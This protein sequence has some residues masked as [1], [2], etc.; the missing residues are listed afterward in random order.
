MITCYKYLR[1][2]CASF[3]DKFWNGSRLVS[4]SFILPTSWFPIL[5]QAFRNA[6]VVACSTARRSAAEKDELSGHGSVPCLTKVT[7]HSSTTA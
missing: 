7:Q 2:H 5:A 4:S 1:N 6:Y 3:V